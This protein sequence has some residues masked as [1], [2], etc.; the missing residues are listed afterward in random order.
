MA[1]INAE[2]FKSISIPKPH[3][4]LQ[5]EFARVVMAVENQRENLKKFLTDTETLFSS[6]QQRAFRGEL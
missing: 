2:E 6:L 4:R 1:N 3:V 5:R